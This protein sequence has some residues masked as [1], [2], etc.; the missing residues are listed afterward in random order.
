MSHC[1]T[2]KNLNGG[3]RILVL[4]RINYKKEETGDSVYTKTLN[5]KSNNENRYILCQSKFFHFAPK[6]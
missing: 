2:T 4:D 3:S 1:E 5:L 6:L